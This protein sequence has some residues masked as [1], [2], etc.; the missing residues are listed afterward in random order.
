MSAL[1]DRLKEKL[2]DSPEKKS[3][4]YDPEREEPVIKASICTGEKEG[5]LKNKKTGEY[6]GMML[7]RDK[8]DLAAF[9]ESCGIPEEEIRTIY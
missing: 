8:E 9:C 1:F 7:I 6:R 3:I 2:S 4:N 5:G